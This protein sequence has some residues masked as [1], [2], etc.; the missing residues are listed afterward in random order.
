MIAI[1]QDFLEQ[2]HH[3][4]VQDNFL[5]SC[6][7]FRPV[8]AI[9]AHSYQVS[10]PLRQGPAVSTHII[11]RECTL[12]NDCRHRRLPYWPALIDSLISASPAEPA[13]LI[14]EFPLCERGVQPLFSSS[15]PIGLTVRR[16]SDVTLSDY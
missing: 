14:H 3:R 4:Q 12:R 1:H 8:P 13:S 11:Y 15:R 6:L 5:L 16:Q 2:N 10:A 7:S 9:G